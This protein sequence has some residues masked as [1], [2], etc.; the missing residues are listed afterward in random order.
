MPPLHKA[1]HLHVLYDPSKSNI[2][3]D[4]KKSV[5]SL[6][7][8]FSCSYECR[9]KLEIVLQDEKFCK[10]FNIN[11]SLYAACSGTYQASG[12]SC[13]GYL[14]YNKIGYSRSIFR[15]PNGNWLCASRDPSPGPCYVSSYANSVISRERVEGIWGNAWVTC[16]EW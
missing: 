6:L 10:R 2:H 15:G 12:K 1:P 11:G 9:N 14:I 16:T 7:L 3:Y 13:G 4:L 5:T 8:Q